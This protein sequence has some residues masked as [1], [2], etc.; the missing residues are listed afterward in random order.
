MHPAVKIIAFFLSNA[1]FYGKRYILV[2]LLDE[3]TWNPYLCNMFVLSGNI[4]SIDMKTKT[5]KEKK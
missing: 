4:Q 1:S 5:K 3:N 2:A